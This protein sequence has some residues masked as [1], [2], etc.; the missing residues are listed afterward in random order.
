MTENGVEKALAIA[1]LTVVYR[2]HI[3]WIGTEISK[4]GGIRTKNQKELKKEVLAG[5][6]E[7]KKDLQVDLAGLEEQLDEAMADMAVVQRNELEADRR[8]RRLGLGRWD[9]SRPAGKVR[10]IA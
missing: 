9:E 6:K 10:K 1:A 3:K 2:R 4:V 7:Y 5:L 8:R